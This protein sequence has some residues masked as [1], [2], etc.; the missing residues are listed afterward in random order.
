[1]S[2]FKLTLTIASGASAFETPADAKV[3]AA[4]LL[5]LA[6]ERIENAHLMPENAV[7]W[8][9]HDVNGNYAGEVYA[10]WNGEAEDDD[11]DY[12]IASRI[13]SLVDAGEPVGSTAAQ[14]GLTP[15]E[16]HDLLARYDLY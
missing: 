13:A 6:A 3:E 1:M 2:D 9:H 4:R 11:S 5:R 10:E 8:T 7:G 16:A 14:F 12:G 15:G